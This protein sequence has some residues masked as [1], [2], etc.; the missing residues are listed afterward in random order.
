MSNNKYK[1]LLTNTLIF[2][3]GTFGSKLLVYFMLPLYTSAL[4]TAEYG[5][6]DLITQTANLL[7]PLAS[8][9]ITSSIVR[10]GLD[11]AYRNNTVFSTALA[12]VAVGFTALLMFWPLL[13]SIKGITG[14]TLL[15]YAY[16]LTSSLR[17]VCAIFVRSI[18]KVKLFAYDGMQSTLLTI[19][20]TMLFLLKLDMGITGYVLAIV[21]A[22]FCSVVFLFF[23]ARLW[24]YVDLTSISRDITG[25]MLRYCLPL[26]PASL[27]WWVTNVSDRYMVTYMI[28]E[29]A[30]G[31]YSVSYKIPTLI[32]LLSSIF[33]EA[34]HMS[35]I[36]EKDSPQRSAFFTKV[37]NAYSALLFCAGGFL[38]LTCRFFMRYLVADSYFIAWKYIP[39]LIL[40]TVFCCFCNFLNSVYV[41]ERKSTLSLLTVM[42]GALANVVMNFIFI[43]S[44]GVMGAGI[45]TML[46][47]LVV[48]ALRIY[49]TRSMIRL[50]INYLHM[51]INTAIILLQAV[52][53]ILQVPY[54]LLWSALLFVVLGLLNLRT[55]LAAVRD[56]LL[57]RKKY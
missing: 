25:Q 15:I 21:V 29:T 2:G 9:G 23:T 39:V 17:S 53:M 13:D 46:S 43:P 45:A 20:F 18:H 42:A 26:I 1:S 5:I 34:W 14:Y 11:K 22:D 10:F 16:V 56:M 24:E 41:V 33:M 4:T 44:M 49:T 50:Q 37:F 57:S 7:L 47:Y 6:T 40:A 54:N 31:L 27:F 8:L 55:L 32:N 52:L 35:A 51:G 19:L 36:S 30:N 12:A 28:D 3:I 38:T 48:F